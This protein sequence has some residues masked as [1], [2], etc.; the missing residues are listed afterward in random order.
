MNTRIKMTLHV[1]GIVL[2]CAVF[3][4][5]A[6]AGGLPL[7]DNVCGAC[8]TD[9]STIMP[10]NHPEVGKGAACLTCH[11]PD[12]GKNDATKFSTEVHKVHKG[13]KAKLECSS[14]HAF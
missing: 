1:C 8:H 14:C 10:K 12:P 6:L 5:A 11:V 13:G 3:G 9:F 7:K 2:M 4:I